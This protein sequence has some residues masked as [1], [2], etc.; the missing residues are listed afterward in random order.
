MRPGKAK[1]VGFATEM[2]E[3]YSDDEEEDNKKEE[4]FED[5]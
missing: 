1:G 4:E 5:T 3:A 2:V